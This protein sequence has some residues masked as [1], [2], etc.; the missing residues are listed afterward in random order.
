LEGVD[1]V[2]L[3][4]RRFQLE[5]GSIWKA[6]PT[7]SGLAHEPL[8]LTRPETNSASALWIQVEM[9][10]LATGE[11]NIRLQN[12]TKELLDQQ[13]IWSFQAT[14]RHKLNTSLGV[15][16]GYLQLIQEIQPEFEPEISEMFD[17][18]VEKAHHL[19]SDVQSIVDLVE[20][21][22]S[23]QISGEGMPL[24]HLPKLIHELSQ[25]INL[26]DIALVERVDHT[27]AGSSPSSMRLSLSSW[28]L[29]LIIRELLMNAKKFHP[30]ACP[31]LEVQ[32]D[33]GAE[34]VRLRIQDD[35]VN[36]PIEDLPK[37]WLP[38]Y[39]AEKQ[40]T[41]QVPGV[42]L[43]LSMISRLVQQVGGQ[44]SAMNR[45]DKPG[46]IFELQIPWLSD[47]ALMLESN[48]IG[49]FPF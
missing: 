32:I 29:G 4:S 40:F 34:M 5:P 14:I 11:H 26:L 20:S 28:A 49:A 2:Q 21:L 19:K 31:T 37:I 6:W 10:T 45:R 42:G 47:E 39:Q 27:L 36:L 25:E 8:Y 7:L 3:A 18:A 15:F 1:F 13:V 16:L 17:I 22:E 33:S 12:V 48:F 35:G 30:Y 38:Y 43:G 44:V 9:M 23:G 24:T 46:M 41:G